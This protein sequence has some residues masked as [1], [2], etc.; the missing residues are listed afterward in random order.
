[1]NGSIPASYD[2]Y[3]AAYYLNRTTDKWILEV[4]RERC[5]EMASEQVRF[6]DLMRWKLGE[7][8]ELPWYGIYIGAKDVAYDLNGDGTPDL[9]VSDSGSASITR[10]VLG[11]GYRLSNGDHGYLEYGYT[12]D[13]QWTDR[14]YLRPIPTAALQ[15]NP[16][17]GQNPGWE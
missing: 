16:A 15:V 9:T 12:I 1:V 6:D 4:R 10:V 3:L 13:R 5:V 14:K 8:I 11:S 7:L 17:L 2:P